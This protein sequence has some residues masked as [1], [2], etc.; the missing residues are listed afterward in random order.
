MKLQH[1]LMGTGAAMMMAGV[2]VWAQNNGAA[3][4]TV[5]AS[6]TS[7]TIATSTNHSMASPAAPKG[8]AR[9]D[10]ATGLPVTGS[11]D[12]IMRQVNEEMRRAVE[13]NVSDPRQ[14]QEAI[15]RATRRMQDAFSGASGG[16]IATSGPGVGRSWSYAR[17]DPLGGA[18]SEPVVV[19]TSTMASNT[20]AEWVED[21]NVMD[22]LLRDELN[23]VE[24]D[25]ERQALGI[26]LMFSGGESQQ[27]IY[28]DGYGV[29][30]SYSTDITLAAAGTKPEKEGDSNASSAWD[31]ARRQLGTGTYPN[32]QEWMHTFRRSKFDAERLEALT[33]AV[34]KTLREA[35]NIRHL[36]ED[37]CVTVTIAG[38][39]DAG[40]PVR[41]TLKVTK[42]DIAKF[43]DQK[44][45]PEEFKQKVA[46]SIG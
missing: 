35:R 38:R 44:L 3:N 4:S 33:D 17:S 24:G 14:M 34:V 43:A 29:L 27:P 9:V 21:L 2:T 1:I 10:P 30:F 37:E 16:G 23:R 19:T 7:S 26:R 40:E 36:R 6:A 20:R 13:E 18:R 11:P 46:R 22:K 15:E 25:T 32:G 45:T 39:D 8:V 28:M 12:D 31:N 5:A 41:L 42:S